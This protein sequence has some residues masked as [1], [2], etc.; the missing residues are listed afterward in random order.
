MGS[1][2]SGLPAFVAIRGHLRAFAGICGYKRI[3]LLLAGGVLVYLAVSKATKR[4]AERLHWDRHLRDLA[5]KTE[6][7]MSHVQ[8]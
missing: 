3:Q 5:Q 6:T 2:S 7:I 4:M 1:T 8:T